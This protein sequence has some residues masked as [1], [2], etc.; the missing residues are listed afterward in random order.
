MIAMA[1]QALKGD[2]GRAAAWAA[3]VRER[4]SALTR[5]DFCRAFPLKSDTMRARVL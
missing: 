5:D 4:N 2:A 1:A 3:N